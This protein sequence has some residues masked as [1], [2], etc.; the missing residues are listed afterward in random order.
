MK[1]AFCGWSTKKFATPKI[2]LIANQK[3][4]NKINSE[5]PTPAN[6]KKKEYDKKLCGKP[7][8]YFA[9]AIYLHCRRGFLF[10]LLLLL[11]GAAITRSQRVLMGS[12]KGG[13]WWAHLSRLKLLSFSGITKYNS[14]YLHGKC[15]ICKAFPPKTYKSLSQVPEECACLWVFRQISRG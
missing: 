4:L 15:S 14:K 3:R 9:Y 2:K 7:P 6:R 11:L 10:A 12:F 13:W 1:T 8:K 5:W